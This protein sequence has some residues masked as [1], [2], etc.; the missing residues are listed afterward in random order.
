MGVSALPG[1][2]LALLHYN[3]EA[4]DEQLDSSAASHVRRLQRAGLLL[5]DA[6]RQALEAKQGTGRIPSR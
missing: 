3:D 1:E 4:D 6:V 5:S 2:R